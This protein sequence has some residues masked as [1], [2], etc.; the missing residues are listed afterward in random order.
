MHV[1][2]DTF[3]KKII[4]DSL[5]PCLLAF[6]AVIENNENKVITLNERPY[7]VNML[8]LTLEEAS[9]S[10][11]QANTRINFCV[12]PSI[13]PISSIISVIHS[14][15]TDLLI[16][17]SNVCYTHCS[18]TE[19]KERGDTKNILKDTTLIERAISYF[20]FIFYSSED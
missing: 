16:C 3:L 13:S 18:R 5:F 19:K 4:F 17:I 12:I 8:L 15:L 9:L 7:V 20:L 10:W 14:N 2:R 1:C 6:R 11:N